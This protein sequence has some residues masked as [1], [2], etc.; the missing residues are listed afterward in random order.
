MLSD[1][2]QRC[3]VAIYELAGPVKAFQD[4]KWKKVMEEEIFMIEKNK[5]WVLVDKPEDRKVIGVRWV[6]RTK[7]NADSSINKYKAR[8][9]VKGYAQIY[10]VDYSDTFSHVARLDTIK[11][12]LAI[13]AQMEW[14]VFKLDVK[15]T[16]LNGILE[17]DIYVEQASGFVKHGTDILI[18]SLYVDDLL[19][20][21]NNTRL[22]EEFKEE[23]MQ[24]F[25][26]TDL[27]LMTYFLGME[28]KPS[29]SEVFI[30]QKKYAKEIL[31]KFQMEECKS[32]STPMN[33][34]E[35]LCKEDGA[36]KV[37]K[38]YYRSLIGCLMY[39]T[40]TR[41]D[42]LFVVSLLSR[43]MHCAS[44]MHLRVAK[45]ILRYIKGTIDYGVK[46]EKCPSFKLLG[47]SDSDWAG[48]ADDMRSTSGHCFSL[49]SGIFLWS[50][51]KQEIVAQSTVEA[52]FIAAT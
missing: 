22:V 28:I 35:K 32:M 40:A 16:F 23:M 8:L 12:L 5:T 14:K 19:V 15:S 51:K 46:F 25:E 20:T 36:D 13:A 1:I 29:K 42:I 4:P 39:L 49:G 18:M 38:G 11:L 45:R 2:Y 3:N 26:M 41:P 50:S 47:F 43:F 34:K 21:G 17:E 48:S 44:E 33:K 24:I 30:C 10:G 52:E 6:F 27:G 31:K 7:L 37:D 9:V